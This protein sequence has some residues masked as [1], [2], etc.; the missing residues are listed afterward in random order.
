FDTAEVLSMIVK[1][2]GAY[3]KKI[4]G[5]PTVYTEE[6]KQEGER[7]ATI[8]RAGNTDIIGIAH[9]IPAASHKDMPALLML[10]FVLTEGKTS[11]LYRALIDSAK[12]TSVSS[13][14]YQF[15]DPS[16][17]I[18]Y[19]TLAPGV[20][21]LAVENIVKDVYQ[22]IIKEGI[23]ASELARAKRMV[24]AYAATRRDG[25][26]A[27]LSSLNE[28]IAAGDWSRFVTLPK[29]LARVNAKTIQTVVAQY[30]LDS[31]STVAYFKAI[32]EPSVE[33]RTR[34]KGKKKHL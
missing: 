18:T 27:L 21:H 30:L 22:K 34:T 12:A 4:G 1:E 31:Q 17:L 32:A 15:H 19:V 3:S 9:K 24:R 13:M 16:L 23:S 26:Y 14:C 8:T 29:A 25:P 5:Y 2:F 33:K 6:P 11:R 28:E 7:R 20:T 10:S